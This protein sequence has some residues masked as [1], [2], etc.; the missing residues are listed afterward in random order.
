M[1]KALKRISS[2]R[3]SL[4]LSVVFALL[5]S[6]LLYTLIQNGI[7][8][9]ILNLMN[10]RPD[11]FVL[12]QGTMISLNLSS[13]HLPGEYEITNLSA[14][15]FY[16]TLRSLSPIIIYGVVMFATIFIYYDV[17]IRRSLITLNRGIDK[18]SKQELDFKL[19]SQSNDELGRLCRAFEQMRGALQQ[20]FEARW[21]SEENQ[22]NLY[23][24]FSHDLRTPLSIVK[25]NNEI[26]EFV[27]A[28]NKDWPCALQAIS[29][30]NRAVERIERYADQLKQLE[31]I[32]DW[33]TAIQAVDMESFLC[34]IRNQAKILSKK[35]GKAIE[36]RSTCTGTHHFDIALVQRVLDNL[37]LNSLR[38]ATEKV[39]VKISRQRDVLQFSVT[40]DGQG[41]S[42][43]AIKKATAPFYTTDKTG[44]HIGIGLTIAKKLLEK[45]QSELMIQNL[46]HG[47]AC[48]KFSL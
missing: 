23:Q 11:S 16:M 12:H 10:P 27:A 33:N 32:E 4:L 6:Q 37:M 45:C 31:S 5:L 15:H 25:G 38:Y 20:S 43:E 8:H 17:K 26:V 14:F 3:F 2:M 7:D 28:K 44:G 18:I 48:V 30:S 42:T 40:D 36:V 1:E 39:T 21:R 13:D 46:D 34:T 19:D 22:R 24:A 29:L 9:A 41:F 47:G 35:Y